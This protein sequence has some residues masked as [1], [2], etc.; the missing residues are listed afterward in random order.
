MNPPITLELHRRYLDLI[1]GHQDKLV[2][3]DS[4]IVQ[5]TKLLDAEEQYWHVKNNEVWKIKAWKDAAE[6][7]EE[8]RRILEEYKDKVDKRKAVLDLLT[9]KVM[10]NF[11]LEDRNIAGQ[12]AWN[13]LMKKNIGA[14]LLLGVNI[15]DL[16]EL[17]QKHIIIDG[18]TELIL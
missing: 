10:E 2:I 15:V 3:E 5:L 12:L 16:P 4:I 14:A 6:R 13:M 9:L 8:R 17:G 1:F 18:N 7:I 11:G